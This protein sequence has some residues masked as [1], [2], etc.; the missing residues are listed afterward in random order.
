MP[1]NPPVFVMIGASQMKKKKGILKSWKLAIQGLPLAAAIG[2]TFLPIH[3]AGQQF[4][5]LIVLV[6][7]Q[8]FFILGIH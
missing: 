2:A 7:I 6:W 5:M 1:S 3:W 4:L 8:I